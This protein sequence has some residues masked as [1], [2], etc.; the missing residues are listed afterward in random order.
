MRATLPPLRVALMTSLTVSE[1]SLSMLRALMA[2]WA[3]ELVLRNPLASM[4]RSRPCGS[5]ERTC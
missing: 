5:S 3:T 2:L 4:P 1:L